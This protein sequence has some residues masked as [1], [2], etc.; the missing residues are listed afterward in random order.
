MLQVELYTNRAVYTSS[1]LAAARWAAQV[2]A[3][4]SQP[5]SN[6]LMLIAYVGSLTSTPLASCAAA[7]YAA[8]AAVLI[9]Q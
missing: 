9:I 7:G 8:Q 5:K 6:T 2:N 4:K 3:L 1:T